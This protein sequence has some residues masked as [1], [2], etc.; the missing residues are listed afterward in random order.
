MVSIRLRF[1]VT[2][3]TGEVME[4]F[5]ILPGELM[6]PGIGQIFAAF[7]EQIDVN[8]KPHEVEGIVDPHALHGVRLRLRGSSDNLANSDLVSLV[9]DIVEQ[10]GEKTRK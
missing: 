7:L 2:S 10:A 1:E 6:V 3:P 8:C 9:V 4:S 5:P